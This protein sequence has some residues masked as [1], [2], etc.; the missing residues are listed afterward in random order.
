M[1]RKL[2]IELIVRHINSRVNALEREIERGEP[3]YATESAR[4]EM[5]NLKKWIEERDIWR[6]ARERQERETRKRL[7][8]PDSK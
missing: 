8:W 4:D 1:A 2:T 5:E 3:F 7:G 6:P